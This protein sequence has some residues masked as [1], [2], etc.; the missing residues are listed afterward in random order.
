MELISQNMNNNIFSKQNERDF[1]LLLKAQSE[2]YTY[3]KK[4]LYS[5]IILSII[6]TII[7]SILTTIFKNELA[8]VGSSFMAIVLFAYSTYSEKKSDNLITHASKIQ[9]TIDVKLF[10]IPNISEIFSDV[11]IKEIVIKYKNANLSNFKNWYSDYSKLSFEEQIFFSQRENTRWD[12]KLREKYKKIII[13]IIIFFI[14]LLI[15]YSI[16]F[17]ITAAHF[18]AI[19]SWG[20][21][22][23]QFV[24][25]HLI[26]NHDDISRLEKISKDIKETELLLKKEGNQKIFCRLCCLQSLIFEHRKKA[27]LIPDWFY[28][29]NQ[30]NM[31]KYEDDLA[32]ELSN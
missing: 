16:I 27:N 31:Q 24:T 9:Q 6:F 20:F 28:K 23:G 4:W 7:F 1:L 15:L 5:G 11:E 13:F 30:K 14:F 22:L 26:K 29:R 19:A 8:N 17:D 18:F 21:P 3:A 10:N 12:K 2:E 32:N 25:L